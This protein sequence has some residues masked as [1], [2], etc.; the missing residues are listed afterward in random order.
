MGTQKI[1]VAKKPLKKVAPLPPQTVIERYRAWMEKNS[2]YLMGGLVVIVVPMLVVWG[3][4]AYSSH[5]ET[6]ARE[7]WVQLEAKTASEQGSSQ[8]PEKSVPDLD[9]FVHDYS[10][11]AMALD[12]EIELQK[13]YYRVKR[14]DDAV[15]LGKEL[16]G[17]LPKDDSLLPVVIY[18]TACAALA[19]GNTEEALARWTEVKETGYP[20]LAREA[21]ANLARLYAARKDYAKAAE[22]YKAATQAAGSY[23]ETALLEQE[24]ARVNL[25]AGAPA[26]PPN[27]AAGG[28]SQ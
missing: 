21:D 10:G 6:K 8:N 5:K 13:G 15:K 4:K 18:Q 14:F 20:G 7:A 19:S 17:K 23:P 26:A 3:A 2:R 24:L 9:K 27:P 22:M 11:T 1:K 25:S 28:G 12:A 16:A